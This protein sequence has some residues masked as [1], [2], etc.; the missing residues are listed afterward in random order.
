MTKKLPG[1]KKARVNRYEYEIKSRKNGS[2]YTHK[3][4]TDING[5]RTETT[6]SKCCSLP[7]VIK[8]GK[9][10]TK[11]E[12]KKGRLTNKTSS[13]GEFV[14]IGYDP[15]CEKISRVKNNKGWS[16]FKY[17]KKCNLSVAK[18]S[19]GESFVLIY[20]LKGKISKVIYMDKS[21]KKETLDFRYNTLGKPVEIAMKG[22]GKMNVIY[23]D[24]GK[25]KNVKS[26]KGPEVAN[27][28]TRTFL[29]LLAV[30]KPAGVNLNSI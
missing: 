8:R 2:H 16:T 11:L 20:E 14:N 15:K 22:V 3:V 28:V 12:Y 18:N 1:S 13:K 17:D 5:D 27:R 4:I 7:L 21:K 9:E 29:S 30:V 26:D 24:I 6:Y 19:D 25:V 10:V 23:N